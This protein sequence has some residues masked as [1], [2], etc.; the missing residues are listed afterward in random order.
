MSCSI[1]YVNVLYK[2]S[3]GINCDQA[4]VGPGEAE[5]DHYGPCP[6][7]W[8]S[9]GGM[10]GWYLGRLPGGGGMRGLWNFC[11]PPFCPQL[12]GL[13]QVFYLAGAPFS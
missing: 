8:G 6:Q 7:A 3:L 5:M 10:P 9:K 2:P 12:C 1:S 11:S 13:G 4:L